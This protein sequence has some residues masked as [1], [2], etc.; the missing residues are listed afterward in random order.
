M[1]VGNI[2]RLI[3]VIGIS[4]AVVAGLLW[5]VANRDQ[6]F[7]TPA[8]TQTTTS[9][10]SQ[11]QNQTQNNPQETVT[12]QSV[13][14]KLDQISPTDN[15]ATNDDK[16]TISGQTDPGNK[17]SINNQEIGVADDGK[18]S[19]NIVLNP[20]TNRISIIA[21]DKNGVENKLGLIYEKTANAPTTAKPNTNTSKSLVSTETTTNSPIRTGGFDTTFFIIFAIIIFIL[22]R[23]A[24][25]KS[26]L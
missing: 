15:F 7:R 1:T 12:D 17:V 10:S 24:P 5:V 19:Q 2:I 14:P 8:P 25:K 6:I 22:F 23:F 9:D 21:T 13:K 11:N 16:V 4:V 3:V 20:G 26:K 18:F